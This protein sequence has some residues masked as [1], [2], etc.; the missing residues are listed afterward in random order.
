MTMMKACGSCGKPAL[1]F[2]KELWALLCASTAPAASTGHPCTQVLHAD[3]AR[4][5][6]D[7]S[8]E[9]LRAVL[10][11]RPPPV[12]RLGCPRN[13]D[14]QAPKG[15]RSPLS[16][17]VSIEVRVRRR[18]TLA[19]QRRHMPLFK[20]KRRLV[21]KGRVAPLGIVPPLDEVEDRRARLG[22]RAE[23]RPIEELT[24]ERREETLAQRV[25]IAVPDRPHRRSDARLATLLAERQR[26]VLTALIRVMD[27]RTRLPLP[28]RHIEGRE[29]Q[30]RPQTSVDTQNR[31]LMDT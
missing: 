26:G 31:P 14:R 27:H 22:G 8:R 18:W 17:R 13:D 15:A 20:G 28:D 25:V 21:P 2:S 12:D 5:L 30:G 6:C 4:R 3:R 10:T 24:L 9:D 23:R 7:R 29:H 16:C 1:R 19:A 11:T